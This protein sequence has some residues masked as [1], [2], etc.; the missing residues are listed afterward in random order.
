MV[1]S[2]ARAYSIG[3]RLFRGAQS[4]D[5][6]SVYPMNPDPAELYISRI[7]ECGAEAGIIT[8]SA[9]QLYGFLPAGPDMRVVL[10]PARALR[11]DGELDKLM[12]LLA[13][14][15]ENRGSYA[16]VLRSAPVISAHRMAWLLASLAAALQGRPCTPGRLS[17]L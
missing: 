5:Y 12:N 17:R 10:G 8:T 13:V 15:G 9:Y 3:V 2:L 16:W 4:L 11:G 6:C 7:L 14:P 1:P